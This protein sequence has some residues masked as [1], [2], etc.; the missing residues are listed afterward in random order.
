SC[1]SSSPDAGTNDGE[2][3]AGITDPGTDGGS[4]WDE[5]RDMLEPHCSECPEPMRTSCLEKVEDG[6]ELVCVSWWSN[7]SKYC[8]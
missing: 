2:E 7:N 5:C 3:D 1:T 6:N 4:S 8:N